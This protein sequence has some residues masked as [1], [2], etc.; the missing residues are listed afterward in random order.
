MTLVDFKKTYSSVG[1]DIL[2][3]ILSKFGVDE[4]SIALICQIVI[5]AYLQIKFLRGL[6]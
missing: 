2:I 4:K 6:S 1:R 5:D 3:K